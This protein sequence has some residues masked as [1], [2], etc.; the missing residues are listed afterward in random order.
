[1]C[2]K[3]PHRFLA[4]LKLI[5]SAGATVFTFAGA[6]Q[7]QPPSKPAAP[8]APAAPLPGTLPSASAS[9]TPVSGTPKIVFDSSVYNFGKVLSGELVKHTFVFT[10]T[11]DAPLEI[12]DVRPGCGCTTAG[13]W[14]KRVEPGKT[15]S[16]PLQFNSAR[17]SGT[18]NKPATVTCND[19]AQGTLTLQITGTVWTPVEVSPTMAMFNVP[20]DAQ[21]NDT[22]ILKVLNHLDDPLSITEVTSSNPA[23][24]TELKTVKPGKEFELY[25][26]A[27]A[28]FTSRTAYAS[29]TLKTSST[30]SPSLMA[31]AYLTAQQAVTVSP[32]Q[33]YLPPGPLKS[34][35]SPSITIRNNGSNALAISDAK[36]DLPG[37]EVKVRELQPGKVF[38]LMASF[39]AGFELQ[40]GQQLALT[41]KTDHPSFPQ[42][43]IP[44][45][46]PPAPGQ[47][48]PRRPGLPPTATVPG[49]TPVPA[50]GLSPAPAPGFGIPPVASP[51]GTTPPKAASSK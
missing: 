15:G 48:S 36:I 19:P 16:I 38:S 23:F 41:V 17:F 45:V 37:A 33:I 30:N 26:T 7:L 27:L 43:R 18:V 32:E 2:A 8:A 5:L 50:P 28:P 25:V 12:T 51:G 21:T 31:S 22:K 24:K 14:D 49:V 1:M 20:G 29:I 6:A 13:T 42:L 40:V 9:A 10:N 34:V 3:S 35:V 4:G 46:Q 44:V 47:F 11:G 39:P